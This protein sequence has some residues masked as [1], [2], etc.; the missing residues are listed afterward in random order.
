MGTKYVRSVIWVYKVLE[1][2]EFVLLPNQPFKS[3][4]EAGWVL[5]MDP[6]YITKYLNT[7]E[8]YHNYIFL[9][10]PKQR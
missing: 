6:K 9:T 3:K 1:N 10:S 5:G 8:V 7:E 2:G 4:R